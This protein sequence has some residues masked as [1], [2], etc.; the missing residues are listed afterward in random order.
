MNTKSKILVIEDSEIVREE[1]CEILN[2]ENYDSIGVSDGEHGIRVATQLKPDLII[3]DIKM[4][5][6]DGYEVLKEL[7]K[8][9]KTRAIPFIFLTSRSTKEDVR[10]GMNLG[11]EDYITKPFTGEELLGAVVIRLKRNRELMSSG[12]KIFSP[13]KAAAQKLNSFLKENLSG[14][15]LL[16]INID[17]TQ[18]LASLLGDEGVKNLQHDMIARFKNTLT[19]NEFLIQVEDGQF[20]I[21]LSVTEFNES[22]IRDRVNQ[23]LETLHNPFSINKK[24]FHVTASCGVDPNPQ[25]D[26]NNAKILEHAQLAAYLAWEAG[27]NCVRYYSEEMLHNKNISINLENELYSSFPGKE[28]F[29]Y[30]QPQLDLKTHKII[31]AEALLRWKSEGSFISPALFIPLAEKSDLILKIGEWVLEQVCK[32]YNDFPEIKE[33]ERIAI[34][35]SGHQLNQAN[36]FETYQ[37]IL[38]KYNISPEKIEVEATESLLIDNTVAIDNLKKVKEFGSSIAVDDFGTGYS[39]LAYIKNMPLSIVKIDRAFINDIDKNKRDPI[40]PTIIQMAHDLNFHVT[41]E[42]VETQAQLDLLSEWNCDVVQGYLTGRPVETTEF[43]N[44]FQQSYSG[45]IT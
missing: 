8:S 12:G 34:N 10:W 39:S 17:R 32:F 35:I 4:P 24:L 13:R 6:M 37:N 29:V 1:V 9:E 40:V 5:N 43:V 2:A 21:L 16:Y 11:A 14:Y 38:N 33:L 28:F 42:G 30:L 41:A 44:I 27:G 3:C 31:A 18:I 23:I 26:N 20:V 36:F 22:E 7:R 15:I 19:K 25:P 45:S